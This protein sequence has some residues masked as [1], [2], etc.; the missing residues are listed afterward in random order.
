MSY[1]RVLY[2]YITGGWFLTLM[3]EFKGVT[4]DA[5]T[6]SI[7]IL[8][9]ASMNRRLPIQ[10]NMFVGYLTQIHLLVD[11]PIN[12]NIILD[13]ICAQLS[14]F[15]TEHV[16]KDATSVYI[17]EDR[18]VSVGL[19]DHNT[20]LYRWVSAVDLTEMSPDV[21]EIHLAYMMNTSTHKHEFYRLLILYLLMDVFNTFG[22]NNT[23]Y[24]DV[25]GDI[26]E[27]RSIMKVYQNVARNIISDPSIV[28]NVSD[29]EF[30]YQTEM[31]WLCTSISSMTNF[32]TFVDRTRKPVINLTSDVTDLLAR[33]L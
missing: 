11:R 27:S 3:K 4:Y 32:T 23:S 22:T 6:A 8:G 2:D 29:Q 16:H 10:S 14:Y 30:D 1:R 33:Y 31:M 24:K 13:C 26:R 9:L 20:N 15:T 18:V 5:V 25:S 17:N 7:C 21:I 28:I 19:R 12:V